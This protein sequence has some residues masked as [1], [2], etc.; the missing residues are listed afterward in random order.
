[1]SFAP[2]GY[3]LRL[4]GHDDFADLL[5][6]AR[7]LIIA[8]RHAGRR[9]PVRGHVPGAAEHHLYLL[10]ERDRS[11]GAFAP[12]VGG[13]VP[14]CRTNVNGSVAAPS[15]LSPRTHSLDPCRSR[16]CARR[17]PSILAGL[18]RRCR[19]TV[20]WRCGVWAGDTGGALPGSRR[21]WPPAVRCRAGHAH[22]SAA[23]PRMSGMRRIRQPQPGCGSAGS[24]GPASGRSGILQP[25]TRRLTPL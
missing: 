13:L 22:S 4:A 12:V 21:V 20:F 24:A 5:Q 15:G 16:L 3:G 2:C 8:C 7:T 11:D 1:M 17:C 9:R 14:G 18:R 10:A 23:V 19:V 6:Q 25:R